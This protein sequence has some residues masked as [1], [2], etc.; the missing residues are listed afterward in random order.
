MQLHFFNQPLWLRDT[1]HPAIDLPR[2]QQ[3]LKL[4]TRLFHAQASLLI[5]VYGEDSQVVCVHQHQA[6]V[7]DS[8]PIKP[9]SQRLAEL[10]LTPNTPLLSEAD[11]LASA[12][13]KSGLLSLDLYWPNGKL[14]GHIFIYS[15]MP[16]PQMTTLLTLVEPIK[17]LI[18]AELKHLYLMKEMDTLS[19]QDEVTCMLNPYGFSLMAPRQLSLGRRFGSHAG[20]IVIE[21]C[22]NPLARK[23]EQSPTHQL[24]QLARIITDN[25]READVCA[26]LDNQQFAVLA[27]VDNQAHLNALVNRITKHLARKEP[28]LRI[29]VGQCFFAPDL[30]VELEL[31]LKEANADLHNNKAYLYPYLS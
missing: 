31:M 19:L 30:H 9:L 24:K 25:M 10:G 11:I 1:E 8:A 5:Q 27:F 12:H 28:D 17:L 2:W 22:P 29:A 4:I 15:A 20:L 26:Y 13:G 18:Q 7:D 16:H 14:F 21:N 23:V 3:Y 6:L